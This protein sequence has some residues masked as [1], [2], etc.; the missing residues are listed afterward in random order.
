M[1][2]SLLLLSLAVLCAHS[3]FVHPSSPSRQSFSPGWSLIQPELDSLKTTNDS[4]ALNWTTGYSG[5]TKINSAGDQ[6][7]YWFINREGGNVSTDTAPVILWLQGGP[8]CASM[9]GAF[10]ELGPF[11]IDEN[12]VVQ[13][14]TGSWLS[15]YHLLFVDNPV[16]AG[17]SVTPK[18]NYVTDEYQMATNLY[19][20]LQN[21]TSLHPEIFNSSHDFYIFGESYAGKY[22]PAIAYYI[23]KWNLNTTA[24]TYFKPI[25]LK[26]IGIGDG[27][28]DPIPQ[29]ASYSDYGF[30][31]GLIDESERETVEVA[32]REAVQAI[33]RKD[34]SKANTMQAVAMGEVITQGGG[35]NEYNVRVFG[36]YDMS[37]QDAWLNLNSTKQLFHVPTTITYLDCGTLSGNALSDDVPQSITG[38]FPFILNNTRVL[39][40]EGQDD[41]ILNSVGAETWI[42]Q[43]QWYGQSQYL[44]A[45][46]QVWTVDGE[47]AG[48]VRNYANLTQLLILKAGHLVP[49]DQLANSLDMVT[50]F[51]TN[52]PWSN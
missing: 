19:A 52:A 41:L 34:W 28:T 11:Y 21:L 36:N 10:F 43:L 24:T 15:R 8:G 23:L 33:Q 40:Y 3:R 1:S 6:M 45:P 22:I 27:L 29:F 16:G 31:T 25:N 20:L 37:A 7:F 2:K 48:Y 13:N 42:A 9:G 39:L 51:I 4:V 14:R 50:R 35:V 32:Q 44:V 47:I 17:Y 18:G 30:A 38:L 5:M 46:K 26:G 12:L 49:H